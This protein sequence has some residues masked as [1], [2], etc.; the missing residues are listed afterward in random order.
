MLQALLLCI[1]PSCFHLVMLCQH[2]SFALLLQ[3]SD[4][5]VPADMQEQATCAKSL[6]HEAAHI[7]EAKDDVLPRCVMDQSGSHTECM[8]S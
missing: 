3:V 1:C 2:S 8:H 7:S 6:Q 4:Q 5:M